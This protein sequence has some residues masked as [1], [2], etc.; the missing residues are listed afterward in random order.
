MREL[1]NAI[2][3][4][5]RRAVP[6][7]RMRWP[8]APKAQL[9]LEQFESREVPAALT[10]TNA[11]GNYDFYTASNWVVSGTNL[12]AMAAPMAGDDVTY[13]GS[14]SSANCTNLGVLLLIGTGGGTIND[15]DGPGGGTVI[16]TPPS[17]ATGLNSLRLINEY[18]GTVSIIAPLQVG[19]F[20]LSA[21]PTGAIAQP[22]GSNSALTVT[23]NFTWTSGTLNNSLN[24]AN[25]S[26]SGA[27]GTIN[28]GAGNSITTG[29]SLILNP[30]NNSGA[31]LAFLPGEVIWATGFGLEANNLCQVDVKPTNTATVTTS[32]NADPDG[33]K[34]V[35]NT[36]SS[37]VVK[38]SAAADGVAQWNGYRLI[39]E[40]NGGHVTFFPLTKSSFGPTGA[41][42]EDKAFVRQIAGTFEIYK[43]AEVAAQAQQPNQQGA[44]KAFMELSGGTLLARNPEINSIGSA[45]LIGN[46]RFSGGQIGFAGVSAFFEVDGNVKWTGGVFSPRLNVTANEDSDF[47][48]ISG[49]L[50]IPN[51]AAVH[52]QPA[53]SN[54]TPPPQGTAIN[55]NFRWQVIKFDSVKLAPN[56]APPEPRNGCR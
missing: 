22:N 8:Q 51:S 38:K 30:R 41:I 55:L 37:L 27:A 15:L 23:D 9:G 47:W 50:D 16:I 42:A 26:L 6:N 1:I 35:F 3:A 53:T 21:A 39:L 46:L 2:A 44:A 25:V 5:F 34:F 49:E 13:D 17:G 24:G 45:R 28:P 32:G 33:P 10:W 11:A 36:G 14:V 7:P 40:N 52:V 31:A 48:L 43:N 29:S 56:A 20:T 12:T 19:T 54:Y 4:T 18:A